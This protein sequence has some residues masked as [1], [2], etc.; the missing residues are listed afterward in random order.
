MYTCC[1]YHQESY[2]LAHGR[3]DRSMTGGGDDPLPSLSL[4]P[5]GVALQ[6]SK[7]ECRPTH[8]LPFAILYTHV[9]PGSPLNPLLSTF[10]LIIHPYSP[11][12]PPLPL[13]LF[14]SK[15]RASHLFQ[16][17]LASGCS[18][19]RCSTCSSPHV[20]SL[21]LPRPRRPHS[22]ATT[23][24]TR[25]SLVP[26]LTPP[27]RRRAIPSLSASSTRPTLPEVP[28]IED[29]GPILGSDPLTADEDANFCGQEGTVLTRPAPLPS[30]GGG[31]EKKKGTYHIHTFGC[32]MNL[33]DSERMAGVL[34]SLGYACTR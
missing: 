7:S 2:S 4:A 19:G 13:L 18:S 32:Q 26:Q 1:K 15:A 11:F 33:A 8:I 20:Y 12:H 25:R 28:V 5:H 22:P 6:G 29:H 31:G 10:D 23:N 17:I 24:P 34:E 3:H 27:P 21:A 16:M 14:E 30:L 9:W